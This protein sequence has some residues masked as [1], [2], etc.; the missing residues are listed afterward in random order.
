M[1][2]PIPIRFQIADCQLQIA[3]AVD[4]TLTGRRV[5]WFDAAGPSSSKP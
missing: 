2:A 1:I 5:R 4:A 3:A